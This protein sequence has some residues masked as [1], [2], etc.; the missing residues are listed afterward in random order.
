MDKTA[1][2]GVILLDNPA[3]L[4]RLAQAVIVQAAKDAMAGSQEAAGWLTDPETANIWLDP[5]GLDS[6][7]AVRWVEAGC[8]N[9][10]GKNGRNR[11]RPKGET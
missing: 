6:G 9:N 11:A 2:N 5:A 10:L 4:E 3:G 7:V 8:K 1:P